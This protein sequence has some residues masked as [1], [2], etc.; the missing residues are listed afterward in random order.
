MQPPN[1]YADRFFKFMSEFVFHP[2]HKA[3][4]SPVLSPIQQPHYPNGP[5]HVP[6]QRSASLNGRTETV[7]PERPAAPAKLAQPTQPP[8]SALSNNND[9]F[10]G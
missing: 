3:P 9:A 8:M 4:T 5:A 2:L 10:S 1:A 7:I 6:I